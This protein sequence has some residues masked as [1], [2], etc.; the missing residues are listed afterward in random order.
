LVDDRPARDRAFKR[1]EVE[2]PDLA[3]GQYPSMRANEC[4]LAS[5]SRLSAAKARSSSTAGGIQASPQALSLSGA[6]FSTRRGEMPFLAKAT[7]AAQ[8]AGATPTMK[9]RG[10]DRISKRIQGSGGPS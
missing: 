6:P 8:P 4:A 2:R 7:P 3:L 1:R 10:R 5:S 9:T